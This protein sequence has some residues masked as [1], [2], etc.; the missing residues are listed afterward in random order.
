MTKNVGKTD[1]V[2]RLI[3]AIVIFA[4]G[5]LYQSWWGLLGILPLLTV[6]FGWCPPYGLF[7]INTNKPKTPVT[8]A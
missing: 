6:V 8:P 2:V 7:G 5:I 1:K 4:L 3:L